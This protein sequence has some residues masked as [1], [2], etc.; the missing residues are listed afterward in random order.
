MGYEKS[1]SLTE[2][3]IK[4]IYKYL[5]LQFF[6]IFILILS[7][8][9]LFFNREADIFFLVFI[10][11]ELLIFCLPLICLINLFNGSNEFGQKHSKNVI[12]GLVLIIVYFFIL[13]VELI[14]SKGLFGAS[15]I[16]SAAAAGFSNQLITQAIIVISLS[17][18]SR[19]VFGK[20]LICFV[21]E[22]VS[23]DEM[24]KLQRAYKLLIV[25]PLTLEITSLIA[26]RSFYK[27][28]KAVSKKI[29]GG[30]LKP[31]VTAPCPNCNRDIP[32]E[33]KMCL[34]CGTKFVQNPEMK[35]D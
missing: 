33:S 3:G 14:L 29:R 2:T 20:A 18:I 28:Y 13:L 26:L 35:I 22:L 10:F 11:L 5:L 23:E 6:I 7:S 32:V 15:S 8:I 1:R 12:L 30:S 19:I 4:Y 31:T 16:V 24:K 21:S 9:S 25:G 34:Y 17:I 27:N